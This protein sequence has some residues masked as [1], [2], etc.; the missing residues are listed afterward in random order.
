MAEETWQK[1]NNGEELFID[2]D[3]QIFGHILNY[4]R[5]GDQWT[6]PLDDSIRNGLVREAEFYKLDGLAQ[7]VKCAQNMKIA[8]R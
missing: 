3:G 5:D 4:L 8:V 7:L 6:L 1:I 2:R